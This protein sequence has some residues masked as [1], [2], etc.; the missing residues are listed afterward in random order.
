MP[1]RDEIDGELSAIG[2][3]IRT[4]RI[5]RGMTLHGLAFEADMKN[6]G[7][8]SNIEHGR[9]SLTFVVAARLAKALGVSTDVLAGLAPMPVDEP[10]VAHPPID[11]AGLVKAK[12]GASGQWTGYMTVEKARGVPR[13]SSCAH[14]GACPSALLAAHPES[15]VA[16]CAAG[17]AHRSRRAA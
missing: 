7:W 4:L 11:A 13:D 14:Y 8:L 1:R 2:R 9:V 15:K 3:R 12:R 16:F 5:L 10:A 6:K 17:C